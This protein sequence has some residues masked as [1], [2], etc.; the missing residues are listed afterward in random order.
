MAAQAKRMETKQYKYKTDIARLA[1]DF[2]RRDAELAKR[3]V[4]L[5]ITM[6]V[7]IAAA[8][9]ILGTMIAAVD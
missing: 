6:V 7:V 3:E 8:T 1:A 5:V 4:R 9:T 2:E